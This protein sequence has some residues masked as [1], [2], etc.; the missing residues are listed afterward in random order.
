M[1]WILALKVPEELFRDTT[2]KLAPMPALI[3][4]F[5]TVNKTHNEIDHSSYV[6]L[7]LNK[8]TWHYLVIIKENKVSK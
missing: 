1:H 8:L 4:M 7:V 5:A 3:D 6:Y 2:L